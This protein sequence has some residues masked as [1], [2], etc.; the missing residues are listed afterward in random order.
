MNISI[1]NDEKSQLFRPSAETPFTRYQNAVLTTLERH[2]DPLK[3][4]FCEG[5]NGANGNK[6][7][8]ILSF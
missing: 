1:E 2:F 4:P 6:G 7:L 8:K 5:Q 3:T